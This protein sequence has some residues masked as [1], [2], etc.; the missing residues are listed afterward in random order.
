MSKPRKK[1]VNR[2]RPHCA[3]SRADLDALVALSIVAI[4]VFPFVNIVGKRSI[5]L[6]NNVISKLLEAFNYVSDSDNKEGWYVVKVSNISRKDAENIASIVIRF[7]TVFKDADKNTLA[8]SF[9]KTNTILMTKDKD[10]A[11]NLYSCLSTYG[12]HVSIEYCKTS[13]L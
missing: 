8:N 6:G 3:L 5:I 1:D 11:K 7:F 12:Y 9:L 4:K 13:E 2:A 10:A